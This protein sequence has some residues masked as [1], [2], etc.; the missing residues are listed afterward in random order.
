MKESRSQA[1]MTHTRSCSVTHR[2]QEW[3]KLITFSSIFSA[4]GPVSQL[5]LISPTAR[6]YY[7]A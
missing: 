2:L 3:Y 6:Y 7:I 5:V 4:H 1:S